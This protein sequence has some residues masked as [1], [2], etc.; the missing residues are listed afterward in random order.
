MQSKQQLRRTIKARLSS[1][2]PEQFHAEGLRA[3]AFIQTL[4]VWT[5]CDTVLLF[6]SVGLCG[7]NGAIAPGVMEC[8]IDTRPLLDTAFRAGKRIFVPRI[9]GENMTFIRIESPDGP[10]LTGPYGIRE[11]IIDDSGRLSP[12]DFPALIIVPGLAF[13]RSGGRLGRGKGYYDRFFAELD[14]ASHGYTT[15]G[16]CMASQIVSAVPTENQDKKM[17]GVA[18]QI[19]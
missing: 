2:P 3:A 10:W 1:L 19:N 17:D 7:S 4:P 13:D 16:L 14:A 5:Q 11:P 18:V 8:E 15:L 12:A 9:E 6:L